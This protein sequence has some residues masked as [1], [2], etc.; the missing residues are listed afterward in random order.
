MPG[1]STGSVD[2]VLTRASEALA[3]PYEDLLA[4]VRAAGALNADETGWRTAGE[5]RALWGLF[6][7]RHAFFQ[8]A[9]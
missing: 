5:R 8:V 7:S 6:T 4:R 2:A 3:E 1:L 9:R